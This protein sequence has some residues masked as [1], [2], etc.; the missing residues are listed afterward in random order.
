M[1]AE[2]VLYGPFKVN[3]TPLVSGAVAT[4]Y[5]VDG[6]LSSHPEFGDIVPGQFVLRVASTIFSGWEE[7]AKVPSHPTIM[8]PTWISANRQLMIF[9]R[10]RADLFEYMWREQADGM[11]RI[12]DMPIM[13]R[14]AQIRIAQSLVH[15]VLHL[16]RYGVAH[17]DIKPENVLVFGDTSVMLADFDLATSSVR[18]S[19]VGGTPRYTPIDFALPYNPKENDAY[20]L[21]V[22]LC[23]LLLLNAV[24]WEEEHSPLSKAKL[25]RALCILG[26]RWGGGLEAA[27]GYLLFAR[28]SRG[29]RLVA[30]N[31]RQLRS[32][33]MTTS[34]RSTGTR[35]HAAAAD[36]CDSLDSASV[37]SLGSRL[38][39]T[40]ELN[41]QT[42]SGTF[43]GSSITSARS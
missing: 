8:H 11:D 39:N 27:M 16:H 9:P 13:T 2:L 26:R 5:I 14:S 18:S 29:L 7:L 25:H 20:A 43:V 37:C 36:E 40:H 38:S 32:H 10:A 31:L 41:E 1:S 19:R 30:R 12:R 21:G 42:R 17:R 3:P 22:T 6:T 23:E 4:I 28:S 35:V 15:A 34:D 24:G 33:G